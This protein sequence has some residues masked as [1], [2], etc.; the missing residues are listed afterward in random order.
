MK[1]S[2][3]LILLCD[4]SQLTDPGA[5]SVVAGDG[6]SRRD[7]LIVRHCGTIAVYENACPHQGTPL[8]TL[9]GRFF[10]HDRTR[11]LC[12]THGAEFQINDGVCTKG[13]CEGKALKRVEFSVKGTAL[14]LLCGDLQS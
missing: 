4:T 3:A 6:T 11:L 14:Y 2:D 8:E 13:P 1:N 7:Y 5:T 10:N 9:A 12:S